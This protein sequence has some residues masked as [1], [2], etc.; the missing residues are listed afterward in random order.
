MSFN[1]RHS[2]TRRVEKGVGCTLR[3]T[4]MWRMLLEFV[5]FLCFFSPTPNC[6]LFS[7]WLCVQPLK[8]C[9]SLIRL[10]GCSLWFLSLLMLSVF[11]IGSN[12]EVGRCEDDDAGSWL[13]LGDMAL[14][15][16]NVR[17]IFEG[18]LLKQLKGVKS[19]QYSLPL[20]LFCLHCCH[21]KS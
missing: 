12:A 20:S 6:P 4:K 7:L 16:Q 14:I 17:K 15:S 5:L 1:R 13:L 2:R 9:R 21:P 10:Q 11:S 18:N 3:K 19:R 8:G